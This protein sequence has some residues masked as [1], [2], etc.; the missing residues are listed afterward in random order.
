MNDLAGSTNLLQPEIKEKAPV[1]AR[2]RLMAQCTVGRA[3]RDLTS[4]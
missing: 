1:V 4:T 3:V 2:R